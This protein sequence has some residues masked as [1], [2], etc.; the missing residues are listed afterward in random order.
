MFCG[1]THVL[2]KQHCPAFGKE[3]MKCN[4]PNHF[5]EVCKQNKQQAKHPAK[6]NTVDMANDEYVLV[7]GQ[8]N[9]YSRTVTANMVIGK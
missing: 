7:V 9:S 6:V 3:C 5:A 1:R 8:Q 4:R 2:D